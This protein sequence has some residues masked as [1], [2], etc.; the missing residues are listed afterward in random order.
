M[1]GGVCF[2]HGLVYFLKLRLWNITLTGQQNLFGR[3]DDEENWTKECFRS[4]PRSA[5]VE[6]GIDQDCKDSNEML[7]D[8]TNESINEV[9]PFEIG[10]QLEWRTQSAIFHLGRQHRSGTGCWGWNMPY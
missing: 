1:G 9:F 6:H 8:V 2:W 10:T 3:G 4:W 7:K 5:A